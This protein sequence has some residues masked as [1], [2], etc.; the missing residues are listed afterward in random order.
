LLQSQLKSVIDKA[1]WTRTCL[2]LVIF[3]L[4]RF[5]DIND[6][7]SHSVGDEV[8]KQVSSRLNEIV[9]GKY[10]LSRMGG[11]EFALVIENL[12]KPEDAA[13]ITAQIINALSSAYNLS[14]GLSVHVNA[15]AGISVFPDH[16]KST[17]QLIQHADAALYRAKNEGRNTY[18]Y[19]SD[20]LT[21]LAHHRITME[22]KLRHA[23]DN[24]EFCVFYQPQVHLLTGRIVG[25]EVLLR[26]RHPTEGLIS[27]SD[28]IPLAEESGLINTIGE[29][30]LREACKQG[31]CWLDQGHRLVLAVNLSAHQLW[32][33]DI[34][35]LV[36]QILKETN[37]PGNRLELELTESALM[38]H[39]EATVIVLHALRALDIRLAIDDFGTGYSSLSYLKR[40]PLD[41]LKIDKSFIDELPFDKEDTAITK[42]IIA[43][44]KALNFSVL[45]EG[46]ERSDQLAFLQDQ[47]CD[48]YQGYYRSPALPADDFIKLLTQNP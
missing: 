26:W 39:E 9:R 36:T 23:I 31:K 8:L 48:L 20:V 6:S 43:M 5:K 7:F 35:T 14:N 29:W 25:A 1:V 33:Q 38:K 45:A 40:F 11:D 30:V 12:Y 18:R 27:P 46:V 37:Y 19:Y 32:H 28:F 41:V 3:D 47:G 4:D 42:A 17:G 10:L 21:E 34:L 13:I 24:K 44:A 22:T 15:S 2:A 16:G